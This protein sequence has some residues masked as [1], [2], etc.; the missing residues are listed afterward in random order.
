MRPLMFATVAVLGMI[1]MPVLA[2][3]PAA[4]GT[5]ARAGH[6]PGVGDSLPRSSQA[7][8]IDAADSQSNVA[9]TLPQSSIGRHGTPRE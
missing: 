4:P 7:S 9:P 2:Q 1:A 6:E 3:A 5:G 8:N